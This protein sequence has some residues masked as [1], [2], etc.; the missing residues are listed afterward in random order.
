MKRFFYSLK[1]VVLLWVA[2]FVAWGVAMLNEW[3]FYKWWADIILHFAGGFWVIVLVWYITKHYKNEIIGE[4][5]NVV[6]FFAFISFVVFVGVF[7][8][9]FELILDRYIAFTGFTYLPKVF[10]DTLLDL[11]MDIFGGITAFL[12]YFKNDKA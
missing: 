1:F 4:H 3:F 12:L 6:T 5:K 8:E 9:F 7:W 2:I 11:V 10:E